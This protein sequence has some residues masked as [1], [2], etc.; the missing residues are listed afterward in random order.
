MSGVLAALGCAA[1][2]AIGSV[3][4][5]KLSQKLDPFTLNAP[6]S[7]VAGIAMLIMTLGTE[8][9]AGYSQVTTWSLFLMLSSILIGAGIG[10]SLYV[11]SFSRIGV[12]QAFP[13]SST[14]PA[15]T[16]IF[17]FLFL[18]EQVTWP[19]VVGLALVLVGIIVM[20]R[21]TKTLN[22]HLAEED[23]RKGLDLCFERLCALGY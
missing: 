10:D 23:R 3:S 18:Q 1:C 6:R 19:L 4:M 5:K 8:R 11:A 15:L 21:S 7:A 2:W 20:G 22:G 12:S 16:L 17:G 9:V 14:Y 13:I